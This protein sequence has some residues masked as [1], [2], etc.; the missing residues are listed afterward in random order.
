MRRDPVQKLPLTPFGLKI[1]IFSSQAVVH[2]ELLMDSWTVSLQTISIQFLPLMVAIVFHEVAHGWVAQRW[3]DPTAKDAGRITL[4]PLAHVDP[5]GTI[6]FPLILMATGAGFLF[7]WA[8]PVPI[9][10]QRFSDFR[11]GL[12]WVSFAGPLINFILAIFSAAVLVGVVQFM[13]QDAYLFEPLVRMA[14]VSVFLN[15]ALGLFNLVPL[16]PLD[17]SK[18]VQSFL[19]F[20]LIH[21][22]EKMSRFGMLILL[23]AFFSGVAQYIFIPIQALARSTIH[24]MAMIFGVPF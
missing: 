7:G 19:P 12:F 15:C 5:I 14:Q 11:R 8:K 3:G 21:S 6:A 16:P 24:M 4:N 18:M 22:Y 20:N 10:P 23:V 9:N 2:K 17:G 1:E 13:P